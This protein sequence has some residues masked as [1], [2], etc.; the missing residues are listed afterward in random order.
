MTLTLLCI[1]L[2]PYPL[3]THVR[4]IEVTGA[5]E[6]AEKDWLETYLSGFGLFDSL[7]IVNGG[8]AWFEKELRT[9]ILCIILIEL[10][11]FVTFL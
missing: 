5:A 10:L 9:L 6:Q 8:L 1:G 7:M 3:Y 2:L 4:A 11:F